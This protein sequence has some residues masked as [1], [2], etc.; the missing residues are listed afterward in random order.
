MVGLR[1]SQGM[2]CSECEKEAEASVDDKDLCLTHGAKTLHMSV[3]EFRTLLIN[4]GIYRININGVK[5][6]PIDLQKALDEM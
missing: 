3:T 1:Q 5:V 2:K 4:R 6:S